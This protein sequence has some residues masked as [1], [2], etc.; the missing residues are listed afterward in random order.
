[1]SSLPR[2]VRGNSGSFCV[3]S[4]RPL[5]GQAA[6]SLDS[7]SCGGERDFLRSQFCSWHG[8]CCKLLLDCLMTAREFSIGRAPPKAIRGTWENQHSLPEDPDLQD[9]AQNCWDFPQQPAAGHQ[10]SAPLC[11]RP[12]PPCHCHNPSP[13]YL[14]GGEEAPFFNSCL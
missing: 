2:P 5:G 10:H 3:F 11:D 12:I 13:G 8:Y 14:A 1:M 6:C 4:S 9:I 7:P